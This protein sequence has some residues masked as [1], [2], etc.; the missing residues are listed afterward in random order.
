LHASPGR[1]RLDSSTRSS[2]ICEWA[3]EHHQVSLTRSSSS[4]PTERNDQNSSIPEADQAFQTGQQSYYPQ[5]TP[6]ERQEYLEE[7]NGELAIH[8]SVLY[9]MVEVFRGDEAWADELSEWIHE[10]WLFFELM[11]EMPQWRWTRLYPSIFSIS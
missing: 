5:L 4:R 1:W 11:N 6:Q 2:E 9:F 10:Q 7:I 3:L 8:L